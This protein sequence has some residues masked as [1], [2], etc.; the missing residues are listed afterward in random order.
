MDERRLREITPGRRGWRFV[1]SI[2]GR[3]VRANVPYLVIARV[4]TRHYTASGAL[5]RVRI[6]RASG[7]HSEAWEWDGS[8]KL[9]AS[10]RQLP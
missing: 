7:V 3:Q 10:S 5:K 8:W 1:G 2:H 6:L 9:L 4:T